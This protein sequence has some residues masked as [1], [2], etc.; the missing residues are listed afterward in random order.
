[1]RQRPAN[2]EATDGGLRPTPPLLA[3]TRHGAGRHGRGLGSPDTGELRTVDFHTW[4]SITWADIVAHPDPEQ[5][6]HHRVAGTG[7]HYAEGVKLTNPR[8]MAAYFAKY[9]TGGRKDSQH[10]VRPEMLPAAQVCD[11]CGTEYDADR[12]DC[13]DCDCLDAGLVD[14][15]AGPDGSGATAACNPFWP[16][17]RSH[18]AVGI[19]AG[20]M[21]RRW[22]RAKYL[23][24]TVPVER[25]ERATG[26]V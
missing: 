1:M 2:E 20:R 26:R 10:R 16:P 24:K 25:V 7:V 8:R 18:A 5:R 3:R 22:Y 6:R 13:P 15:D 12:G 11:D 19:A 4:L 23:T 14:M 9:G 17:V 21:L